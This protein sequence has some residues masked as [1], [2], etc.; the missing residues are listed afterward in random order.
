[1]RDG[2]GDRIAGASRGTNPNGFA[3]IPCAGADYVRPATCR[4][5]FERGPTRRHRTPSSD[6][7]VDVREA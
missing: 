3:T 5:S 4:A 1:M 7:A 2:W 6:H